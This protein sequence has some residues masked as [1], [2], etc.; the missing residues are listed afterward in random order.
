MAIKTICMHF[1]DYVKHTC[2]DSLKLSWFT[3]SQN[4]ELIL[5]IVDFDE[6]QVVSVF[7]R[8]YKTSNVDWNVGHSLSAGGPRASS[9]CACGVST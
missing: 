3:S 6:N 2:H 7:M 4:N 5:Q 9:A 8:V 1:I